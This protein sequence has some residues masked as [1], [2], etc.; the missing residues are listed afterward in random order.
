MLEAEGALVALRM[1]ADGLP[2]GAKPVRHSDRGCQYCCHAYVEEFEKHGMGV[3][4]TQEA[5]CYENALT[6][7]VNGILKQEYFWG[8]AFK[9]KRPH[10]AL[11]YKTPE[12]RKNR[13]TYFRT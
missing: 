10:T 7:R 8:F 11:K 12:G 1:A 3:S 2:A 13:S 5:H 4:M 6:E 9:T